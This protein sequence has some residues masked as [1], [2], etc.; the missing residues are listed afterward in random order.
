MFEDFCKKHWGCKADHLLASKDQN[1][2]QILY[3]LNRLLTA[4]RR[5]AYHLSQLTKATLSDD[6]EFTSMR[7]LS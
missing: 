3:V 4:T 5:A 2:Q 1:G 6:G 7:R